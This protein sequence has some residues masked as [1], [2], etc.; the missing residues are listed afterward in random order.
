MLLFTYRDNTSQ[1]PERP[2]QEGKTLVGQ[3]YI[4]DAFFPLFVYFLGDVVQHCQ[5]PHQL[6][7]LWE[8]YITV[9]LLNQPNILRECAK[10][11]QKFFMQNIQKFPSNY[12]DFLD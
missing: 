9:K 12:Y 11:V 4:V 3:E 8:L 10:S 6:L 2:E 7:L 5:E 1:T